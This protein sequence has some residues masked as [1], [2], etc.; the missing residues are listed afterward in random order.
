MTKDQVLL[1]QAYK[2][3]MEGAS[4]MEELSKLNPIDVLPHQEPIDVE[5][6][7]E[8]P[9]FSA[10]V[11]ELSKSIPSENLINRLKM[12]PSSEVRTLID[13]LNQLGDEDERNW[14]LKDNLIKALFV[15]KDYEF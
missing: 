4:E 1:E 11:Q 5:D 3:V 8:Q 7:E 6:E 13:E 2:K 15:V 12:L 14:M 9:Q 10:I